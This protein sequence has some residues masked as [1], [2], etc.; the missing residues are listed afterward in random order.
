[1]AILGY[2]EISTTQTPSQA[3]RRS[4]LHLFMFS[5]TLLTLAVLAS[6]YAFFLPLAAIFSPLGHEVVIWL[7][8]RLENQAAPLYVPPER[9][10]M[11]LDVLPGYPAHQHA[12]RTQDVI[13]AVNGTEVDSYHALQ[14][15]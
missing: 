1:M 12:L 8:L 7:G 11:I 2:G 10:V 5:L 13:L 6:R 3:T 14:N 15:Q 4:S 9:G